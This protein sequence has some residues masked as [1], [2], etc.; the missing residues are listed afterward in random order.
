MFLKLHSTCF[1]WNILNFLLYCSS[2]SPFDIGRIFLSDSSL[3]FDISFLINWDNPSLNTALI[4]IIPWGGNCCNSHVTH[5]ELETYMARLVLALASIHLSP[6]S[7]S[8][9][10]LLFLQRNWFRSWRIL[11]TFLITITQL[12]I[13]HSYIV[14]TPFYMQFLSYICIKF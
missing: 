3:N 6:V 4:K 1:F 13:P 11:E 2:F 14:F 5:E 7:V 8:L 9:H 10:T 12:K